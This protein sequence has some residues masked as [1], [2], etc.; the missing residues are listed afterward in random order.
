MAMLNNQRVISFQ[1]KT[2]STVV[3]IAISYNLL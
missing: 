1:H 3:A 2:T